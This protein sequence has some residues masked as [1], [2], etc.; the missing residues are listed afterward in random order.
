MQ[1]VRLSIIYDIY[2]NFTTLGYF[3]DII[4]LTSRLKLIVARLQ[5]RTQG[6]SFPG[7]S[8][9]PGNEV[10]SFNVDPS[11]ASR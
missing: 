9:Y 2:F 10:R 7:K 4:A 5:P 6:L 11:P 3:V 1:E 8:R